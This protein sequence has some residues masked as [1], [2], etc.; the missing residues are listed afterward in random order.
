MGTGNPA[1]LAPRKTASI[2]SWRKTSPQ[3]RLALAH[4]PRSLR[5]WNNSAGKKRAPRRLIWGEE[6]SGAGRILDTK[7]EKLS[8]D[9]NNSTRCTISIFNFLSPAIIYRAEKIDP[10]GLRVSTRLGWS[11]PGLWTDH[12]PPPLFCSGEHSQAV[13]AI[14]QHVDQQAG[15]NNPQ[16]VQP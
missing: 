14:N 7:G 8:R 2:D 3:S 15:R 9:T 16:R 11:L 5:R 1:A 12:R 6:K 4:G 13:G 10:F